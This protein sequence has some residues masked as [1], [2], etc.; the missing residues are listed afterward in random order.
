M[1]P[2]G[3]GRGH[4][5]EVFE[6]L[7][8]SRKVGEDIIIGKHVRVRVIDAKRGQVRLG[9]SAPRDVEVLRAELVEHG[10]GRDKV[11]RQAE[12]RNER[13]GKNREW[14]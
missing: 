8:L 7:V 10:E 1:A 2:F 12:L 9:V 4:T 14:Q 11:R 6:M 5:K 3:C 13:D